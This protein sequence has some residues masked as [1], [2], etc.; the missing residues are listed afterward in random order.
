MGRDAAE[1]DHI[2]GNQTMASA[3]QFEGQFTF[4]Q[5]RLAGNEHPHAQHI[6]QHPMHL[7]ALGRC[8]GEIVAQTVDDPRSR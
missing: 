4:A 2:V 3:D 6:H 8:F 5:P 7:T 1:V